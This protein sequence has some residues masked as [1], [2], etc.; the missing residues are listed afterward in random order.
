V[1]SFLAHSGSHLVVPAI[2]AA[3]VLGVMLIQNIVRKRRASNSNDASERGV[4][5]P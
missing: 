1:R 3:V 5:R 2:S 4:E